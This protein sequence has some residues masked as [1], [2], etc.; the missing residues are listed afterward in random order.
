M[1]QLYGKL[2]EECGEFG[3]VTL[4][5]GSHRK[6]KDSC[7]QIDGD[8]EEIDN[9]KENRIRIKQRPYY[10]LERAINGNRKEEY[11]SRSKTEEDKLTGTYEER[12]K[13]Y[14]D[15]RNRIMNGTRKDRNIKRLVD[16]RNRFKKKRQ[17][18]LKIRESVRVC[19]AIGKSM[20]KDPRVFVEISLGKMKVSGLL[21]TGASVNLLGKNCEEFI[22]E[23]GCEIYPLVSDIKTAGGEKYEI[24]GKIKV[25]VEFNGRK[26]DV[27]FYL[28]PQLVQSAYLG[29]DFWTKFE[30]APNIFFTEEIA[31]E[32]LVSEYPIT[33]N[34]MD[35]HIL[36]KEQRKKLEK[37]KGEFRTYEK[38]G[39]G[40]TKL[41]EH[42]I[43]LLENTSP[44]KERYYP[45]SPAVQGLMYDEIDNMLKLGVIEESNSPWSNRS[46][47]VRKP[48]KNR[49]CLDARK[50]NEKTIKDA[51]P[52]QNIEGILSRL[53]ETHY[54]SSVD[55]KHAFWQIPLEKKSK[56]YTAFTIP[57]RPLY[58][59]VVMPFGLCNAAQS[60]CRLM[61][62]VIPEKLKANV[63]VYLDDLLIISADFDNHL[64]L[65]SQVAGCLNKANLTIGLTKS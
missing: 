46:T 3:R 17:D 26:E 14:N 20:A 43:E 63:F 45:V 25:P 5:T 37:V 7:I 33:M 15:I 1:P 10:L 13:K 58:Q 42:K 32:K 27:E 6:V 8:N 62:K 28:C 50:L 40:R 41:E 39:L 36:S 23:L 18:F 56:T 51:Y 61:D 29:V 30:L 38:H 59:Y 49:E 53:D 9:M 65:L 35:N 12:L 47:L 11:N 44:I 2:E 19:S 60:L 21:D 4:H 16:T 48:G 57:G 54:I 22:S 34:D 55:L 31:M 24:I 52:N 64:K